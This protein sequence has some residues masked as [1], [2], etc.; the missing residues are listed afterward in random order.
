MRPDAGR[1]ELQE[2]RPRT[3]SL[4]WKNGILAH[5]IPRRYKK[6]SRIW[7]L[8][9]GIIMWT[10]WKERNDAAFGGIHWNVDKLCCDLVFILQVLM[11]TCCFRYSA[12]LP[13]KQAHMLFSANLGDQTS[14]VLRFFLL[15]H[16]PN[17]A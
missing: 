5:R 17:L 2:I 6:V 8:L 15:Q 11:P 10:L 3:L 12:Q 1:T 14:P 16:D 7:L 9:R 13:T 4:T